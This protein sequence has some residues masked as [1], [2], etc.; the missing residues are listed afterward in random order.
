[1]IDGKSTSVDETA[2]SGQAQERHDFSNVQGFQ[3]AGSGIPA[4]GDTEL[5]DHV[6]RDALRMELEARAARFHQAVDASIVLANDGI[7]RWLGDPIAKLMLGPDLLAPRAV[8]LA[9]DAL[10]E[11]AREIVAVRIELWL[12]AVTQRLLAPLFAL[13]ALQ[14]ESDAIRDL[15]GKIAR[16]LGILDRE[17]I[18]NQVRALDQNAR[19]MLRKHGVRFG[20]YY[21]YVPT[22]LKPAARVLA[23]QLW[24]LQTPGVG[25][26][27]LEQ[28]L[29]SLASSGRTSLP[30]DHSISREGYRVA[31]FRPCG[32]RIVR[33]DIVER[34][35]DMIRAAFVERSAKGDSGEAA[36]GLS[37]GFVVSGQMTSLTG[38]SGEH[39]AS[40][41][42]SLGF[43]CVEMKRSEFIGD[44]SVEPQ[45]MRASTAPGGVSEH[46]SSPEED[47][48]PAARER[49]MDPP[50]ISPL[51]GTEGPQVAGTGIETASREAPPE[52][53]RSNEPETEPR[54]EAEMA[55]LTPTTPSESAA[56]SEEVA[57]LADTIAVWRPAQKTRPHRRKR[58]HVRR[59]WNGAAGG[60]PAKAPLQEH[61]GSPD[62]GASSDRDR[63]PIAKGRVEPSASAGPAG[64][65][66]SA[67]DPPSKAARPNKTQMSEKRRQMASNHDMPRD[68]PDSGLQQRAAVDPNSPFAKLVEL[69]S[70]LEAQSKKRP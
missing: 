55:F 53:S 1:M 44:L 19:A 35:A 45:P 26:E 8:I 3:V 52:G 15:A 69:R 62:G 7:I 13:Q 39:F 54:A 20:A 70:L 67:A 28:T 29:A 30:Y 17:P 2:S 6:R 32:D 22:V 25:A 37:R 49:A 9:D 56:T 23:L 51:A 38:C 36:Q 4:V 40:I 43:E 11:E 31:G 46:S 57:C 24:G 50:A 33:V 65:Q 41:L 58:Q 59:T 47:G 10:P 18:R 42:R 66:A 16:S 48:S 34:L 14:E 68:R 12:A 61:D 64:A 5:S 60:R 27:S 63:D 21:I